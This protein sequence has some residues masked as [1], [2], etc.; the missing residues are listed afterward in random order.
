MLWEQFL[1][2]IYPYVMLTLFIMGSIYRYNTDQYGWTTR[3]SELLDKDGLRW[4]SLL[5]HW[6]ILAAFGG[7]L[8]GLFIPK[9]LFESM[10]ITDEM[11]HVFAIYVGGA[12]GI[13]TL[14]G[15]SLLVF[16]RFTVKRIYVISTATDLLMAVLLLSIIAIG[17]YNTVVYGFLVHGFSYRDTLSPW[18]R[19]LFLFT[20]DATLMRNVPFSFQLHTFIALAIFGLWPFT[21]LVHV[22]SVP[23]GYLQR[24][25]I[26]Y[27]HRNFKRLHAKFSK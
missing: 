20:P 21:R 17:I 26:V 7:H 1:W 23:L 4:G 8:V 24:S 11:Y 18:V 15:I 25:Y 12:A 2:I 5:F 9:Q 3:S 22:W 16:R 27:R 13:V 10:G 6:G 19:G 14:A